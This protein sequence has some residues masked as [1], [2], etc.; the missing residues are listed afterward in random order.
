MDMMQRILESAVSSQTT[1]DYAINTIMKLSIRFNNTD[2][3]KSIIGKYKDHM[4]MELQQ[5][6]IEYG[7][8]FTKHDSM[9]F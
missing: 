2:R 7:A 8:I 6:S 9:R 5:R 4:D 3:I 1:K